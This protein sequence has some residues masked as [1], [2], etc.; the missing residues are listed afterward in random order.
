MKDY[1]AK[2]STLDLFDQEFSASACYF[3]SRRGK[4]P[5]IDF[6]LTA[7]PIVE[8]H[9]EEIESAIEHK[10]KKSRAGRPSID[11]VFMFQI[12]MIQRIQ[13]LSDEAMAE[14]LVRDLKIRYVLGIAYAGQMI[15]YQ[16]IWKYREQFTEAGLFE[17][18]FE[19]ITTEIRKEIPQIDHEDVIIDSTFNV[20]PRQR[21]TKEEN[22][23]IKSG[24]GK[25]LWNDNPH[26]KCHKDIDARWTKKR[27]ETF[28]GYKIHVKTSTK[29]KI[30]LSFET[31]AASEHDSQVITPLLDE[32]D[33]GKSLYA[34]AGYVGPKQIEAIKEKELE[35]KIC[36]KGYRNKPLTEEQKSRNRELSSVRS[37]IEHVFGYLEQTAKGLVCRT[38]GITRA[39]ANSAIT[40]LVY[41]LARYSQIKKYHPDWIA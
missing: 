21:N 26:K 22:D 35:P 38:I 39:K 6:A 31:T 18:L 41:N 16:T 37:L 32:A 23:I 1:T 12:L 30:A 3:D 13:G 36:E 8:A 9:R 27:G 40:M 20:S 28:Y 4:D 25:S 7:I 34:D 19:L 24:E 33:K 10:R 14:A 29:T 5:F 17:K 15:A 11:P 2:F